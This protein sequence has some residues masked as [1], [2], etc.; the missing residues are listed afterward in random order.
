MQT[1]VGGGGLGCWSVLEKEKLG[2][3]IVDR[4]RRKWRQAAG[5]C[6]GL[7]RCQLAAMST[8]RE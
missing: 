4:E 6:R 5:A 2:H 8:T 1:G 3:A 7:T